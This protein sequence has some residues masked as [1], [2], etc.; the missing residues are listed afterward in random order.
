M[1]GTTCTLVII[2]NNIIYY[3][4]VGDSLM[5][6]SKVLTQNMDLNT[7]NDDFILTK[8]FHVPSL[9]KEKIRIYGHRGEVRGGE[10]IKKKKKDLVPS[11]SEEEETEQQYQAGMFD[12]NRPRVYM[13]GRYYPG[14]SVS[15][16]FG[17]YT[18]HRI[19]VSSEPTVGSQAISRQN[20]FLV[21]AN[22]ALW[23]VLTPKEVFKFIKSH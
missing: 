13:R 8:P 9:P 20:E 1:S 11:D 15:R 12:H 7:T 3:G 10:E 2:V 4:F 23:N 6:L 21:L 19:G 16:S 5:C 22:R 18:A 17:D 14:V